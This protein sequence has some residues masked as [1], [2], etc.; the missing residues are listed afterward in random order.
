MPQ[1][2]ISHLPTSKSENMK[3]LALILNLIHHE[4]N[5]IGLIC[6]GGGARS[7]YVLLLMVQAYQCYLKEPAEDFKPFVKGA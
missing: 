2:P 7:S 4:I 5:L 1:F 6:G 3:K